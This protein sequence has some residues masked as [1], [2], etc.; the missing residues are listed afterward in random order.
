MRFGKQLETL[1][2]VIFL[3]VQSGRLSY[4]CP[5]HELGVKT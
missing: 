1:A 2:A 3:D 5:V 4:R